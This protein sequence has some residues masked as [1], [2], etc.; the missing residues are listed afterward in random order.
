MTLYALA[1]GKLPFSSLESI[2]GN[3]IEYKE[4]SCVSAELKQLIAMMLQK[5]PLMRPSTSAI[6]K[7]KPLRLL[8]RRYKDL[9]NDFNI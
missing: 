4:N 8:K 1:F 9:M 7:S 5:D 3:Q 6:L 2:I